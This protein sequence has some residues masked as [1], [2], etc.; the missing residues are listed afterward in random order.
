[1]KPKEKI[2]SLLG[3]TQ[4]EMAMLLKISRAQWSMYE[5]GKRNLP[6][7]AQLMM[8]KMLA[9]MQNLN[10][11]DAEKAGDAAQLKT[12]A[13]S[14]LEKLLDKNTNRLY[15]N[16]RKLVKMEGSNEMNN[17]ALKFT[18]FLAEMP[19]LQSGWSAGIYKSIEHRVLRGMQPKNLSK[20][21]KLRMKLKVLQSENAIL[22]TALK[23][24]EDE[25][26]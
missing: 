2:R 10:T 21:V 9:Y 4:I 6:L 8:A 24:L 7:P 17:K 23:E 13:K 5:S 22:K 14:V 1:M 15:T 18:V 19:E 20:L 26:I 16:E 12:E 3:I 11:G 25:I